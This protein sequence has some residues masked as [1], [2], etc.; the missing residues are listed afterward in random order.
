M[1]II[2]IKHIK[3]S[4]YLILVTPR[5]RSSLLLSIISS[6]PLYIYNDIICF[7]DLQYVYSR[8]I[9]YLMF[10]YKYFK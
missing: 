3:S 6:S 9:T 5:V 10:F 7:P 1:E 2:Y 4:S 8:F